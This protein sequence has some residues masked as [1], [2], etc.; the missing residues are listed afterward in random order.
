[1]TDNTEAMELW[2]EDWHHLALL[3]H[4]YEDVRMNEAVSRLYSSVEAKLAELRAR[5]AYLE[6]KIEGH[7][8]A[9]KDIASRANSYTARQALEADHGA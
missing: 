3:V 8:E 2:R 5:I 4:D 9:M 1:M 6:G 7:A